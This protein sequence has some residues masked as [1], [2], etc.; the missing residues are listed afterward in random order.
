MA[1]LNDREQVFCVG[2]GI[3]P[4]PVANRVNIRSAASSLANGASI[5]GAA[6]FAIKISGLMLMLL[7]TRFLAPT[8]YGVITLSE[9]IAM[10]V[11]AIGGLG[12]SSAVGRVY[13]Q[14]SE[15]TVALRSY[16]S[17]VIPF[18][19]G[20]SVLAATTAMLIGPPILRVV[21]PAFSVSFFPFVATAILT[22]TAQV[23]VDFRLLLFQCQKRPGAFAAMTISISLLTAAAVIAFVVFGR[24]GAEGML[25][26]KCIVAMSAGIVSVVL[27]R[28]WLHERLRWHFIRES[29]TFGIPLILHSFMALGLVVADRFILERYRSLREVGLYSVAYTLGMAMFIV[30]LSVSQAW[31]PI[32]FETANNGE[33]GRRVNGRISSNLALFLVGIAIVGVILADEFVRRALDTRYAEAGRLIPWIIAGYLLHG[34]FTLFH[35]GVLQGKRTNWLWLVSAV[36]LATNIALN[37]LFIPHWGMF[38]AAW[39]TTVSYGVEA[40]AVYWCAQRAY[41][42]PY[43]WSQ[44]MIALVLFSVVLAVSQHAWAEPA[45]IPV[46]VTTLIGALGLLAILG[47]KDLWQGISLLKRRAKFAS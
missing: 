24:R 34:L 12:L 29:L 47:K 18:A 21:D 14:Y 31:S 15:N 36:A 4:V 32:Y 37:F 17:T 22:A 40:S 19:V 23:V 39:A 2:E 16:T 42:L 45:R 6:N 27:L 5:Y 8:D 7:C 28:P 43:D 20:S 44:I 30:T 3:L 26:G 9:T 35:L 13:F 41:R 11:S 46:L 1:D 25:L 38:G 10:I 33:N